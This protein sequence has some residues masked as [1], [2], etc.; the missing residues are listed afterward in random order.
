MDEQ[1]RDAVTIRYPE[2]LA[3]AVQIGAE[4]IILNSLAWDKAADDTAAGDTYFEGVVA[5]MRDARA[6]CRG[7]GPSDVSILQETIAAIR[8]AIQQP[9]GSPLPAWIADHRLG[10]IP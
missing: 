9:P 7:R 10:R 3:Q 4:A 2:G 6:A 8:E 1:Q 5:S